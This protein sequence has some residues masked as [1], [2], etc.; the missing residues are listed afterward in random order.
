MK[1]SYNHRCNFDIVMSSKENSNQLRPTIVNEDFGLK[2][3]GCQC[4]VGNRGG[5]NPGSEMH[6]F[7]GT[8]AY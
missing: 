2:L 1:V 6:V 4:V 3:L 8:Y 7:I 5:A